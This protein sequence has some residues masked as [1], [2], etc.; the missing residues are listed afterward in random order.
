M[1][2]MTIWFPSSICWDFFYSVG[3]T[4]TLSNINRTVCMGSCCNV[5]A[6]LIYIFTPK[7]KK[8]GYSCCRFIRNFLIFFNCFLFCQKC[9]EY[10]R[11]FTK[12]LNILEPLQTVFLFNFSTYLEVFISSVLSSLLARQHTSFCSMLWQGC[13]YS[14]LFFKEKVYLFLFK[15]IVSGRERERA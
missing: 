7:R 3:L 2:F 15:G 10:S 5:Y 13:T 11:T 6:V 14:L 9:F 12:A 8:Y 4:Y 1:F